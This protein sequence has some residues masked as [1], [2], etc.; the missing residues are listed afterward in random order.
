METGTSYGLLQQDY[1]NTAI[2]ASNTWLKRTWKQLDAYQIH[3]KFDSPP[4]ALSR[5]GDVLL[6][7]V[8][9]DLEVDQKSLMWLNWCAKWLHAVALSD[10]VTADGKYIESSAWKGERATQRDPMYVWPRVERPTDYWWKVWRS[11]LTSAFLRPGSRALLKPLG[12]WHDDIHRW[13]WLYSPSL[14][15]VFHRQ[16][17]GWMSCPRLLTKTRPE[18]FIYK[19]FRGFRDKPLPADVHRATVD[20]VP[21]DMEVEGPP[22]ERIRCFVKLTGVDKESSQSSPL[23]LTAPVIEQWHY[24]QS[25]CDGHYG[26]VPDSLTMEGSEQELLLSLIGGTLRII[27]DG[28]YKDGIGTSATQLVTPDG[29][30]V[31]WVLTRVPGKREDQSAYRSEL[32]GIYAGILVSTWLRD[33]VGSGYLSNHSPLVEP[34]CDGL[35]AL[36]NSFDTWTLKA[37]TKHFDLLSTIREAVRKAKLTWCPRHVHGHQDKGSHPQKLSWWALRNI[38]CDARAGAY[39]KEIALSGAR[40]ATNPRFFTELSCLYIKGIK[41]PRLNP[42]DIMELITLPPLLHY[43]E[44]KQRLSATAIAEVNWERMS[45]IMKRL[46]SGLQRWTTKLASG[47]FGVGKFKHIWSNRQIPDACPMCGKKENKFHLLQCE[48]PK[49][50]LEWDLRVEELLQWMRDNLTDPNIQTCLLQLLK[51]IRWPAR[52]HRVGTSPFLRQSPDFQQAIASQKQLGVHC[53]VEGLLSRRWA[54]LQSRHFLSIGSRRSGEV[55]ADKAAKQFILFGF[56]I[57]Q[58]RNGIQHSDS[59]FNL[60]Q[61]HRVANI[62]IE[63]QFEIGDHDQPLNVRRL[64]RRPCHEILRLS[65]ADRESWL[66]TITKERALARRESSQR[67]LMA[68][69]FPPKLG[70]VRP[71][72]LSRRITSTK[73]TPMYKQTTLFPFLGQALPD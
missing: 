71:R 7:D 69:Q 39:R 5:E 25:L 11:T 58:H 52:I 6:N 4:L 72:P 57:W 66:Q 30:H 16:G 9:I 19:T 54:H 53:M 51:A 48:S 65:L 46:P 27:S 59:N 50:Q 24:H 45:T 10:I 55:W 41:Q 62:G 61:R 63:E 34:A 73:P 23:P 38:E 40:E 22:P 12:N 32:T 49:V 33:R 35:T 70:P 26:W 2:L 3:L 60:Q 15:R 29:K 8:F 47:M 1:S 14:R 21:Q 42:H 64:L 36:N 68:A 44:T 67:R 56:H 28:S 31:L 17:H 20:L 13:R 43:W 18:M 37:T